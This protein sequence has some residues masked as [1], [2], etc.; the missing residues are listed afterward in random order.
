MNIQE[1]NK[2]SKLFPPLLQQISS[3]PDKI[4]LA[5][6]LPDLPMIAI[7]GSRNP[8]TYGKEQTY[9][10]S[11]ELAKSGICI[12]SGLAYGIDSI[13][14]QAVNDAG[15]IAVAVLGTA[16]DNIYPSTNRNLANQIV[17]KGG[18]LLSEYKIGSITQ[19]YNFPKRNRIIAGLSL[20]TIVT[21]AN[22]QSGSLITANFAVNENRIVMAIPGNISNPRSAGPNH[23][24]QLGAKLV[25]CSTDVLSEL[26]LV[27]TKIKP[28]KTFSA[29]KEEQII[30][31]LIK[32][33]H[34]NM[35]KMI[36]NSEFSA[37]NLAHTLSLMEITGKIRNLGAGNW[38]IAN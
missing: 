28:V 18:G 7:V 23:L 31:D 9:K 32:S 34:I 37:Q 33:G 2:T 29:S 14:H 21:E 27:S 17:A 10:I 5:G 24:I 36:E 30:L 19:K 38:T 6:Q 25:T 35:Q 13:A 3:P 15:G 20:A 11:Y 1:I 16:L 26:E 12:V 22:A 4:Y 8:S